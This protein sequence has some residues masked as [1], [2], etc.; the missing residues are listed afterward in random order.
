M[1]GQGSKHDGV[2]IEPE[3]REIMNESQVRPFT[4]MAFCCRL[5]VVVNAAG[6]SVRSALVMHL[7]RPLR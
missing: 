6:L 4:G 7:A 2:I 3:L 5:W 1:G